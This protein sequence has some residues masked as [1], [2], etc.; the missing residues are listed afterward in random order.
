VA[1][2]DERHEVS[3]QTRRSRS[4]TAEA[5]SDFHESTSWCLEGQGTD[6]GV[7]T[8]DSHCRWP[9]FPSVRGCASTAHVTLRPVTLRDRSLLLAVLRAVL[10]HDL[11]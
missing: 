3:A 5:W 2:D 8:A 11:S 9:A 7:F 4:S 10:L 1:C 6:P